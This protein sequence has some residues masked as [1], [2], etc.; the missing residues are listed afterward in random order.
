MSFVL[1]GVSSSADMVVPVESWRCIIKDKIDTLSSYIDSWSK[2][3]V[4]TKRDQSDYEVLSR[5]VANASVGSWYGRRALIVD[6][7]AG[8]DH[9]FIDN[10]DNDGKYAPY[11]AALLS[12]LVVNR[13]HEL[14]IEIQ[15]LER[16]LSVI[17]PAFRAFQSALEE[18]RSRVVD[19]C[20]NDT[21]AAN[22]L[23]SFFWLWAS[24]HWN[25]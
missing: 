12:D 7:S 25:D 4:L 1:D 10:K 2:V 5:A 8:S 18:A 17:D 20:D 21:A 19:V 15:R 3:V 6:S 9:I 23:L 11:S 24:H 22:Q 16:L 14:R 13:V